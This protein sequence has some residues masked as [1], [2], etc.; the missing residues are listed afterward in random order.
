MLGKQNI[1]NFKSETLHFPNVNSLMKISLGLILFT[2]LSTVLVYAETSSDIT[3]VQINENAYLQ[4]SGNFVDNSLFSSSP[5]M[6]IT[7]MNNDVVSHTFVSGVSNSNNAGLVANY[8]D[9]L[10]CELNEKVRPSTNNFT[11]DNLCDFNKDDR[12]ITDIIP[13]GDST[14]FLLSDLGTYRIIDPDYPWIEFVIYVFPDSNS[15]NNINSGFPVYDRTPAQIPES[16]TDLVMIPVETLLVTVD[17]MPFDV[18]YT[19]TGLSVYEIES[20]TDS[21]S[22]IFYVTVSDSNGK[23][24]VTFEREFFDSTYDGEDD[25]FFVLADGDEIISQEIETTSQSRSLT[26][27]VPSGTEELEIIGSVFNSFNVIETPVVETPVVETPVVETSPQSSNSNQCGPGT[28]LEGDSC[29]LDQRCGPGTVLEGD[30]C[31]LNPNSIS[32]TKS[33]GTSK[34]LIISFTGALAIAGTVGIIFA[35]ISRANRN[36]P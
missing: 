8:D 14:S 10:I 23:L 27:D 20:D 6:T 34:E 16:E 3:S 28:V 35:L 25:L 2:M 32:P 21:M 9:Y 26:I 30:S 11:D 24:N 22:L 1:D 18:L 7:I 4:N 12:I 17:G 36:K 33:L 29:V 13:P 19:T 15:S 5:G 31:V